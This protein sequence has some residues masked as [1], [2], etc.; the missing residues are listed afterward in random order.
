MYCHV[1]TGV[2]I[3]IGIVAAEPGKTERST[4]SKARFSE[5]N[6]LRWRPIRRL[7]C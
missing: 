6:A 3:G 1:S 2:C 7:R 5:G 4:R